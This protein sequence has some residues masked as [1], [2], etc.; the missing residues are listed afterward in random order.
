MT[1]KPAYKIAHAEVPGYH[2]SECLGRHISA[3]NGDDHAVY[4]LRDRA[5]GV[6][7]ELGGVV[8][9]VKRSTTWAEMGVE[10]MA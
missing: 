6:A 1:R 2:W 7:E 10:E 4:A 9:P 8:V 5:V 3:D